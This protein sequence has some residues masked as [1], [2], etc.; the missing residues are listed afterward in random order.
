MLEN[1]SFYSVNYKD[2][3]RRSKMISRFNTLDLNLIFVDPV[4]KTD[5]RLSEATERAEKRSWSIMLQHLDSI[6]HFVEK[7]S[8]E[9]CIVTEDDI[10]IS[11]DIVTDLPCIINIYEKLELDVLLLGFLLPFQIYDNYGSFTLMEKTEKYKFYDYPSDI[12]GSQMYMVSR[13]HALILLERYTILHANETIDTEPFSPDW[14]LTK[15]G[16]KALIYPMLAVEDGGTKVDFDD[17]VTFHRNCYNTNY[18]EGIH[19]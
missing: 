3:E 4:D 6:R 8:C 1:V 15:Y 11:K 12:W 10:L 19:F 18:V 9:Y 13:R 2:E 17:E 16:K 14:T 5:V 7:T